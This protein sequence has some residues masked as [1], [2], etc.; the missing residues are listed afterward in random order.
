[1]NKKNICRTLDKVNIGDNIKI[2]GR[3]GLAF[4]YKKNDKL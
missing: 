3:E 4:I 1:M 2:M